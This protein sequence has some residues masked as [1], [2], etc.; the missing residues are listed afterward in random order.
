MF[1]PALPCFYRGVQLTAL[2]FLTLF[3]QNLEPVKGPEFVNLVQEA[4]ALS[5]DR[6]H[7]VHFSR[8][9][10]WDLET[11]ALIET[12]TLPFKGHFFSIGVHN[13]ELLAGGYNREEK[14]F[15]VSVYGQNGATVT[16]GQCYTRLFSLDGNLFVSPD[17]YSDVYRSL[18]PYP[19]SLVEARVTNGRIDRRND[20]LMLGKLNERNKSLHYEVK[21]TYFA[22]VGESIVGLNSL[23]PTLITYTRE[24]I[25]QENRDG[26]KVETK[27]AGIPLDLPGWS[28]PP[29]HDWMEGFDP[30][31]ISSKDAKGQWHCRFNMIRGLSAT[32]DFLAVSYGASEFSSY[33]DGNCN[34]KRLGLA[35][36]RHGEGASLQQRWIGEGALVGTYNGGFLLFWPN[37]EGGSLKPKIETLHP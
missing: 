15:F 17:H 27:L 11:G 10:T 35:I 26:T 9:Y 29:K 25:Q 34:G 37:P 7:M 22:M 18:N 28:D 12:H 32:K 23:D 24:N 30:T 21:T 19:F 14:K 36:F 16:E 20:G 3:A 4:F 2:L 8:I 31:L 33:A 13:S 1:G 5:G 6:V